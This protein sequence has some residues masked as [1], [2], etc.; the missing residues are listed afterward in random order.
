[1]KMSIVLALLA[2]SSCQAACLGRQ[3]AESGVTIRLELELIDGSRLFGEPARGG[4][5]ISLN[6]RV[7]DVRIPLAELDSL[8]V[9]ED[10]ETAIVQWPGGDRLSGVVEDPAIEIRTLL[11]ELSVPIAKIRKCTVQRLSEDEPLPAVGVRASGHYQSQTARQ[12]VDGDINTVWSSAAYGGWIEVD[13]GAHYALASIEV[14]L[15][16]SPAGTAQ[17]DFYLSDRP[18]HTDR[19]NAR[20]LQRF[21]GGRKNRDVLT[22][23]CRAPTTAR[24]V[25]IHCPRSPG[26]FNIAEIKV[27][28]RV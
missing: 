8:Q 23:T 24:Y 10:G 21:R 6:S 16:L 20:L 1:M 27:Y 17:H 2:A 19:N 11:G 7:G 14:L 3:P 22:S 13:L 12:A 9:N 25:Q 28:P 4:A 5:A 15:R 26:W 18:M